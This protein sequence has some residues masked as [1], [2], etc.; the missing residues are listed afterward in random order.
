M[1]TPHAS[2][3]NGILEVNYK[4]PPGLIWISPNKL[5]NNPLPITMTEYLPYFIAKF[6]IKCLP[7]SWL[8]IAFSDTHLLLRF[9]LPNLR[10]LFSKQN[11][12]T[13]SRWRINP[14]CLPCPQEKATFLVFASIWQGEKI[15]FV[16]ATCP[17]VL[18]KFSVKWRNLMLPQ[19]VSVF[20]FVHSPF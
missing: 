18:I 14:S 4:S 2:H 3:W 10:M 1:K 6:K 15:H 20:H 11:I 12:I 5:R 17:G 19:P 8:S 9:C 16:I 7:A 13:V